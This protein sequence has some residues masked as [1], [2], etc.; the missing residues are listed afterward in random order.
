[1]VPVLCRYG[2][3]MVPVWYRFGACIVPVLCRYGACMVSLF[4]FDSRL[5]TTF[6]NDII[7]SME[8]IPYRVVDDCIFFIHAYPVF[9]RV[10]NTC[11]MYTHTFQ[12]FVHVDR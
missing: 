9:I 3:G 10:N 11:S 1:M 4:M 2:A 8:H 6:Y 7:C 12:E 5:F